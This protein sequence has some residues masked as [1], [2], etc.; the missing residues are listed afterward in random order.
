[1]SFFGFKTPDKL[2]W[3]YQWTKK[4]EDESLAGYKKDAKEFD[5]EFDFIRIIKE[6]I[7][8]FKDFFK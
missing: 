8:K 5:D 2:F 1:M 7:I 4:A 6:S 3:S